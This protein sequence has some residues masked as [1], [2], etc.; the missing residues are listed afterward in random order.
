MARWLKK[1]ASILISNRKQMLRFVETVEEILEASM[2]A[3][4]RRFRGSV[5]GGSIN[6]SPDS[7]RLTTR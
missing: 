5:G 1:M 7:F 3:A 4:M 6:G 2:R